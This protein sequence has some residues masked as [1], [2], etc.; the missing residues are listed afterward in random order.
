MPCI[1]TQQ[2]VK[3]FILTLKSHGSGKNPIQEPVISSKLQKKIAMPG[4]SRGKIIPIPRPLEKQ[5]ATSSLFQ[6]ILH[7]DAGV[8][9]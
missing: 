1:S 6:L 5:R 3:E 7:G 9:L 8:A 2:D 4:A